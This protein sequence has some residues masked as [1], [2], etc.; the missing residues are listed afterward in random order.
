MDAPP[1]YLA[2][3]ENEVNKLAMVKTSRM[4]WKFGLLILT[5]LSLPALG[6]C[7]EPTQASPLRL[8]LKPIASG[9]IELRL[10]N[11]GDEAL[12]VLTSFRTGGNF[13]DFTIK[14]AS[15]KIVPHFGPVAKSAFSRSLVITLGKNRFFGAITDLRDLQEFGDAKSGYRLP[16]GRYKVT[17]TYQV[18]ESF[19]NYFSDV[20]IWTGTLTSNE[21]EIVVGE[22]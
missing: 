13:V 12:D 20:A 17:A 19:K 14:D 16:K 21:V 9:E 10:I 18:P 22:P 2:E 1:P 4:I 3:G 15:N 8:E 5:G 7:D 11:E 6:F